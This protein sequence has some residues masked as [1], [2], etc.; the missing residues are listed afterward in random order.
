MSK[1]I[2]IQPY[3]RFEDRL[4]KVNAGEFKPIYSLHL[5]KIIEQI[6][7]MRNTYRR[8]FVTFF[9]LHLPINIK[10]NN[11]V[12]SFIRRLRTKLKCIYNI[13]KFGFSWCREQNISE[14]PHYHFMLMVNGSVINYPEKLMK[15][16]KF[17]WEEVSNGS[18][19]QSENGYYMIFREDEQVMAEVI[20]RASYQAKLRTKSNRPTQTK[21]YGTSRLK[22]LLIIKKDQKN[23]G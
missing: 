7:L 5:R 15:L 14:T 10:I 13:K 2:S 20:Y 18:A 23:E 1:H 9:D 16:I 3:Y 11:L 12:T 6:H 8:V 19:R 4:W 17:L 21:T 22:K